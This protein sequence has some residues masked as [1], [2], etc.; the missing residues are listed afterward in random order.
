MTV[1]SSS[2]WVNEGGTLGTGCRLKMETMN[3]VTSLQPRNTHIT[4]WTR[5]IRHHGIATESQIQSGYL[6][7][8]FFSFFFVV[9]HAV[10]S[11]FPATTHSH[12]GNFSAA[13]L[14]WFVPV[15]FAEARLCLLLLGI[16]PNALSPTFLCVFL[17]ETS[18]AVR[19]AASRNPVHYPYRKI[20]YVNNFP[21]SRSARSFHKY[22]SCLWWGTL[23]L[24][25][26][27]VCF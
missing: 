10:H 2:K 6:L 15:I 12:V 4:D 5:R 1:P 26:W 20:A 14:N 9:L 13:H 11:F 27:Y 19:S 3:S 8:C 21:R 16:E 7:L 23:L 22:T 18:E 17:R 24:A 25:V